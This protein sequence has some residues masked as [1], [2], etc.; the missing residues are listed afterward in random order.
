MANPNGRVFPLAWD[1]FDYEPFFANLRRIGYEGRISVEA[2]TQD[3]IG[4]APKSIALLRRHA[5]GD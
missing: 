3:L 5:A 2:S 1:E 4:D